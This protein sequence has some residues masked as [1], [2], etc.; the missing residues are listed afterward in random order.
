M[1]K[2]F[3]LLLCACLA[4]AAAAASAEKTVVTALASE[5]NPDALE[6]VYVDARITAYNSED[7]TLAVE[8]IV[9]ER[10]DPEEITNLKVGDAI[11]TEGQEVEIRSISE[12]AGYI[13]L[14]AGED[15]F[16]DGSVWLFENYDMNYWIA[17]YDD[18]TWVSLATISVPVSDNLLFL[19]HIEPSSG[20]PLDSPTVHNRAEFL[21]MLDREQTEGP[22]FAVNN[23]SVVFDEHGGIA[24]I[25]RCYVPWQ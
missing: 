10:Y 1:K 4:V 6:S 24:L 20:E 7:N 14:N 23:T 9:P 12:D 5:V 2:I 16:S 11:Y 3:C 13:V 25:E 22:G 21:E 17:V 15:E 19:D 18:H 8:V